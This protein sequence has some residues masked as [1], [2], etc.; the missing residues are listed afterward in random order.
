MGRRKS[1][2]PLN[3]VELW[4]DNDIQNTD[5]ENDL[6]GT[7]NAPADKKGEYKPKKNKETIEQFTNFN[8][9]LYW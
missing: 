4:L 6:R 8:K 2:D 1:A 7:K 5:A 3:I 9:I